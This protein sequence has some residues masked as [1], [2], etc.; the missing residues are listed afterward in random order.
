LSAADDP[1]GS[2]KMVIQEH[3]EQVMRE[4]HERIE[5]KEGNKGA[6]HIFFLLVT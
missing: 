2:K 5:T 1:P 6:V 3:E 4:S